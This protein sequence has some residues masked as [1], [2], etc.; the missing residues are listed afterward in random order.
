[1]TSSYTDWSHSTHSW[2]DTTNVYA[3]L[4]EITRLKNKDLVRTVETSLL[5]IV[6]LMIVLSQFVI[7]FLVTDNW[8]GDWPP[9]VNVSNIWPICHL[10]WEVGQRNMGIVS[11][12]IG[13]NNN[14]HSC[15]H[16]S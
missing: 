5:A 7:H 6:L 16:Q 8:S 9:V 15:T 14:K 13:P 12:G 3:K 4:L 1:M 10:H 2:R 11:L